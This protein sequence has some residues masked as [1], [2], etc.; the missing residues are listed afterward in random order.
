MLQASGV[1]L[2]MDGQHAQ[3]RW[4]YQVA[5]DVGR[6]LIEWG[7][8]RAQLTTA[9]PFRL[10]QSPLY[11]VIDNSSAG[12]PDFDRLITNVVVSGQTLTATLGPRRIRDAVQTATTGRRPD[13]V[14]G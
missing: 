8:V 13:S 5:A 14:K 2:R 9:N 7:I 12:R 11:F 1:R 4:G 3:I 6:F 10:T